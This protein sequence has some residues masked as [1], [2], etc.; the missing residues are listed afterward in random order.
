ME[1][2]RQ[3]ILQF[4]NE[5]KDVPLLAGFVIGIYM[6]LYYYS[7]NMALANSWLRLAFFTAFYMLLPM[8]GLYPGFKIAGLVQRGR[9]QKHFLFVAIPMVLSFYLLQLSWLDQY[10]RPI[11]AG[12]LVVSTLLSLKIARY[13]KAFIVII[14]FMALF[15]LPKLIAIGYTAATMD[16]EWKKQP[17]DIESIVFKTKPNIYYL[18]PDGYT[19]FANIRQQPYNYDNTAFEAFLQQEGFTPYTDFRSNYFSTLLSNASM[20]SMK[21]HYNPDG[22]DR[23]FGR[24]IIMGDN[25]V[26]R[27]LKNNGYKTHFISEKP[28]LIINRPNLGYDD[29]NFGGFELLANRDGWNMETDEEHDFIT[30]FNQNRSTQ[31]NF[32]FLERMVPT[33]ISPVEKYSAGAKGER[34]LYFKRLEECNTWIR[35]IVGHIQKNDPTGLI[36]ITADHGG[37]VGFD[38]TAQAENITNDTALVKSMFGALAAIKWNNPSFTE[39]DGGLHTSVNLFRTVFAFLAQDKKYLKHLDEDGSY[40]RLTQPGGTYRAIDANGNVGYKKISD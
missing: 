6:L 12:I 4:V 14:A 10:K 40:V 1:K 15:S 38:Y 31:G 7:S 28:Y 19:S 37:F 16:M 26:L 9:W 23:L 32:Y 8:A 20:F 30:V 21:H 3:K 18:Q 22:V 34:E 29:I 39:Y 5:P 2:L 11:F 25:P 24:G 36:I 27:I 13:Y 17:D 35:N 33:H